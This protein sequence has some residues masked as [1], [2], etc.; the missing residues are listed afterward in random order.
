M[1]S[2]LWQRSFVFLAST[3]ESLDIKRRHAFMLAGTL[4]NEYS[5]LAAAALEFN[6]HRLICEIDVATETNPKMRC[7]E[8]LSHAST[9][10]E[11]TQSISQ[12][13]VSWSITLEVNT[14]KK[15]RMIS[16]SKL[17]SC[18]YFHLFIEFMRQPHH[19]F[20]W[21][22]WVSTTLPAGTC[23]ALRGRGGCDFQDGLSLR[24]GCR[25]FQICVFFA[26]KLK[27]SSSWVFDKLRSL[28]D[29]VTV[30]SGKL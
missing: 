25:N 3:K 9:P 7:C 5:D 27:T 22:C 30:G 13:I 14:M 29:F 1:R 19:T 11:Y 26:E 6:F 4:L 20:R 17:S 21:R 10:L 2:Y 15:M 24:S 12:L 23:Y 16:S 18:V 8:H 28:S